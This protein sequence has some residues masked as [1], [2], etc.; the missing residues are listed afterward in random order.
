MLISY[1]STYA[2]L[3]SPLLW[4]LGSLTRG[5]RYLDPAAKRAE[6]RCHKTTQLPLTQLYGPGQ[7]AQCLPA[8]FAP[9]CKRGLQDVYAGFPASATGLQ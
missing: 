6:V 5:G 2:D 4:F 9:L 1:R 3:K 8:S 7:I